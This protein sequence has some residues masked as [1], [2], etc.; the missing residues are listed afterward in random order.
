[1]LKLRFPQLYLIPEF[2]DIVADAAQISSG[3]GTH[4]P[5]GDLV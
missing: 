1:M 4:F 3:A 2:G 5:R